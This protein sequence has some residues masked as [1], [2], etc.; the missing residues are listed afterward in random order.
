MLQPPYL[1]VEVTDLE[2][3]FPAHALRLMPPEDDIPEDIDPG[4]VQFTNDWFGRGLDGLKLLPTPY[5]LDNGSTSEL[6]WRHVSG[7]IGSFEPRHQHKIKAISYLLS[8]WFRWAEW[9]CGSFPEGLKSV[10]DPEVP[11][12]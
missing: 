1:P 6:A 8:L 4:W 12:V 9:T 5:L 10:G 3:A 11:V 2:L 7:I